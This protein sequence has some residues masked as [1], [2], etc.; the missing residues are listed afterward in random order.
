[1]TLTNGTLIRKAA[2][3]NGTYGLIY[4]CPTARVAKIDSIL[5]SN[6][7]ASY[8]MQAYLGVEISA[9][10]YEWVSGAR[11]CGSTWEPGGRMPLILPVK[12]TLEAGD[13]IKGKIAAIGQP[14][15][16]NTSYDA[17]IYLSIIEFTV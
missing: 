8:D 16:V 15:W 6:L 14:S 4:T 1:V 17:A 13:L 7:H 11:L 10:I 9:V 2:K 3:I 12:Q 5:I